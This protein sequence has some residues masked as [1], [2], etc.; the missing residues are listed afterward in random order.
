[1]S[2]FSNISLKN[3]Q[4]YDKDYDDDDVVNDEDEEEHN[5]YDDEDDENEYHSQNNNRHSSNNFDYSDDTVLSIPEPPPQNVY[6][7]DSVRKNPAEHRGAMDRFGVEISGSR[8]DDVP[9][10]DYAPHVFRYLRTSCYGI[11]DKKY[12]DSILPE[13]TEQCIGEIVAKFSEGRSGAFFFYTKD[14]KYLIK[15]LTTNE[16]QLLLQILPKYKDYYVREKGSYLAKFFGLHSIKL[17]SLVIYFVVMENVFPPNTE[18]QETYDIKGSW[19]A[20]HTNHHSDAGKLMKDED[21]HKQL[22][23]N[24][25]VSSKMFDQL[26]KD[27]D[28]LE[29]CGIMDYSLLLGIYYMGI[30]PEQIEKTPEDD[31]DDDKYNNDNDQ[32]ENDINENNKTIDD[33]NR[34][35]QRIVDQHKHFYRT[36]AQTYHTVMK[37]V[38]NRK[39]AIKAKMIEGPGIYYIGVIDILQ[40]WNTS[41][42][43]ERIFKVYFRCLNK[44]GISCV[45]P[46]FYRRRFL[47]KMKFIGIKPNQRRTSSKKYQ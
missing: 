43:L 23:L 3:K 34:L 39:S 16:A 12:L 18:P 19:I 11:S 7:P 24:D 2:D 32:D 13:D 21:L 44:D 25:D 10:T 29:K 40:K 15:T 1:M 20:R 41:K 35:N 30:D 14:N 42:I 31:L 4:K 22:L 17:Y 45:E 8:G 36:R 47:E 6:F 33:N 37:N 46:S 27:S 28:F 9:F 5:Y 26:Y 38:G